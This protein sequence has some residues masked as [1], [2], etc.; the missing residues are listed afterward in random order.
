M[1]QDNAFALSLNVVLLLVLGVAHLWF[2]PI[3]S[4]LTVTLM[5]VYVLLNWLAPTMPDE[6]PV[7]R[8]HARAASSIRLFIVLFVVMLAVVPPRLWNIAQRRVDGG[9]TRA[10]ACSKRRQLS[11]TF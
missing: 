11:S 3:S 2:N 6:M 9:G 10:M 1:N 8:V 5:A 7:L 4:A